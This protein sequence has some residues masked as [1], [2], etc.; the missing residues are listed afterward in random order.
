[1]SL[2]IQ[3][4]PRSEEFAKYED[5]FVVG[6]R[7]LKRSRVLPYLH[8]TLYLERNVRHTLPASTHLMKR[9]ATLISV[10]TSAML[11]A[12]LVGPKTIRCYILA[13]S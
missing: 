4:T 10:S 11:E 7:T 1:M 12:D 9:R 13:L 2:K 8:F 6:H 5:S 3:L